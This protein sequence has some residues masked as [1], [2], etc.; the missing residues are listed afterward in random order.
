MVDRAGWGRD[1]NR[2]GSS[3]DREVVL[4][5]RTR[6]EGTRTRSTAEGKARR[7]RAAHLEGERKEFHLV[8]TLEPSLVCPQGKEGGVV[9]P[10]RFLQD[11][12]YY[13][14]TPII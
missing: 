8:P 5:R 14:T 10:C 3:V 12:E 4:E 1:M 11:I 13:C 6:E 7:G 2:A 9:Q